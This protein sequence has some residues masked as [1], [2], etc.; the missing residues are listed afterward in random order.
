LQCRIYD[1]DLGPDDFL[2]E[3]ITSVPLANGKEQVLA[4]PVCGKATAGVV[5]VRF[6]GPVATSGVVDPEAWVHDDRPSWAGGLQGGAPAVVNGEIRGGSGG[7]WSISS[8]WSTITSTVGVGQETLMLKLAEYLGGEDDPINPHNLRYIKDMA[9]MGLGSQSYNELLYSRS[10]DGGETVVNFP[11]PGSTS[12][13][14]H[15]KVT[16]GLATFT[17]RIEAGEITRTGPDGFLGLLRLNDSFWARGGAGFKIEPACISL[18]QRVDQHKWTRPLV[19]KSMD[20]GGNPAV[21]ESIR[22]SAKAYIASL[23]AAKKPLRVRTDVRFWAIQTLH[24]QILDIALTDEEV[25][26]FL[27]MQDKINLLVAFVPNYAT[28]FVGP[29]LGLDKITVWRQKM[30]TKYLAAISA[31][32]TPRRSEEAALDD[33]QKLFLCSNYLD[34]MLFAG[35]ASIGLS[36]SCSLAVIYGDKSPLAREAIPSTKDAVFIKN[37]MWETIRYFPAVVGFPF[38]ASPPQTN[39]EGTQRTCLCLA[40]AM[41]DPKVWGADAEDYKLRPLAEYHKLSTAFAEGAVGRVCPGKSL[42]LAMIETFIA[43]FV[44]VEDQWALPEEEQKKMV[45]KGSPTMKPANFAFQPK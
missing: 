42:A 32:L 2:G 9:T 34:A 3:V 20:I 21:L 23:L 12:V 16:E 5:T 18:A 17:A 30:L 24:K 22:A 29:L 11:G 27:V 26:E 1:S 36:L 14:S 19:Q 4:L 37:V 10:E 44:A 45:F 38:F 40:T 35:G 39:K 25:S 6:W 28:N 8:L 33:T 41:K 43:E 15:A 7:D 31:P 13:L